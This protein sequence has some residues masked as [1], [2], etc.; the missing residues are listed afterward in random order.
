MEIIVQTP[1]GEEKVEVRNILKVIPGGDYEIVMKSTIQTSDDDIPALDIM[2]VLYFVIVETN[3]GFY[4]CACVSNSVDDVFYICLKNIGKYSLIN[5]KKYVERTQRIGYPTLSYIDY[6]VKLLYQQ[7]PCDV[8]VFGLK[9]KESE[10]NSMVLGSEP[11]K[12]MID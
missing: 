10:L 9:C 2:D 7:N 8:N 12:V 4:D 1:L 3:N 6:A 5:Y 11:I